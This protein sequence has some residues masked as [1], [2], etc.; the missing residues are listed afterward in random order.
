M[1]ATAAPTETKKKK[2]VL[3]TI[4]KFVVPLIITVGLCYLLFT[5]VDFKEM[6]RIIRDDCDFRWIGLG[7]LINVVAHII[8]AARWGIQLDALDCPTPL[9]YL[10]LSIF[11]TYSINL[12]FP[13][14]GEV[15]RSGYIAQRQHRPFASIFGSMVCERLSDTVAV[16]C[17][18]VITF[19]I[20]SSSIMAFLHRYP[21]VYRGIEQVLTSPWIWGFVVLVVAFLIWLTHSKSRNPVVSKVRELWLQLWKGFIVIF[22]MHGKGR[23]LLLTVFLWTTYFLGLY[24][25]FFAFP[26]TTELIDKNGPIV[27]L[28]CFVLSSLAMGIPSNG[29]IGPWQLAVIFGLTIYMPQGLS[30]AAQSSFNLHATAFANLVMGAQTL[31]LICLGI[32]TFVAIAISKHKKRK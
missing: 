7:L 31:L 5:G 18:F 13:R 8:R 4:M 30:A 2:S 32:F 19:F 14:L 25:T 26:F 27:A 15:W 3:A 23:W 20:A 16:L 24:V 9:Y 28:V 12:V 17:I 11:G 29:G 6:I 1:T 22:K 21:E 10:V